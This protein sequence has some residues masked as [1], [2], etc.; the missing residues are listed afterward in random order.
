MA[1]PVVYFEIV[2]EDAELLRRYYEALFGWEFDGDNPSRGF[3]YATFR[4]NAIGIGGT[5]GAA[6]AGVGGYLTFYVEVQDVET[7]LAHA[8][9]LGGTRIYGPDRVTDAVEIG[10]FADPEGNVVGVLAAASDADHVSSGTGEEAH[11]SPPEGR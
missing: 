3:D 6:P 10:M 9:R 4:P 1:Q 2:G 8:D 5:I 11:K 7:A